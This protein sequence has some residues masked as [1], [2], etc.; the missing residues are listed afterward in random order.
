VTP[1][2][3]M[4]A[5][6]ACAQL[7]IA[8]THLV[9]G[10]RAGEAADL[11]DDDG[12]FEAPDA[13]LRLEGREAIRQMFTAAQATGG[14]GRHVCTNVRISATGA[15][16][17]GRSYVAVYQEDGPIPAPT[18]GPVM[19]ADYVDDFVETAAGWRI[20]HRRCELKLVRGPGETP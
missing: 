20:A 14:V 7:V 8:Y 19:L 12:V 9:D 15:R 6:H 10:G 11:F 3:R 13:Q 16:A 4:V 2:E 5:E 17:E 18:N 1:L